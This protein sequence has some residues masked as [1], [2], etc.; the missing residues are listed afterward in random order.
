VID[1]LK[2]HADWKNRTGHC[3]YRLDARRINIGPAGKIVYVPLIKVKPK[4]HRHDLDIQRAAN[5]EDVQI[6][7]PMSFIATRYLLRPRGYF[8]W[9]HRSVILYGAGRPSLS[10]AC[11]SWRR[12]MPSQTS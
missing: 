3:H 5:T 10:N 11:L 8:M 2:S 12:F 1:I 7:N 6:E 9:L 4:N